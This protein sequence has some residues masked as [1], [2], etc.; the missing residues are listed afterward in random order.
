MYRMSNVFTNLS[1][2]LVGLT[3]LSPGLVHAQESGEISYKVGRKA[4]I[5]ITNMHGLITVQ[6]S[7]TNEVRVKY[8]SAS[9]SVTF[10][11]Q[12]HGKRIAL[13]A[14]SDQPGTN[15]CEYLVLVPSMALVTVFGGG[16]IRA[17]GLTGDILLE[18]PNSPLEIK[19]MND[20]HVHIKTIGGQITLTSVHN[21]H[22]YVHSINGAIDISDAADSWIEADSDAGRIAYQ[23]DPGRDGEYRLTTRSGDLEISIPASAFAEIRTQL[24]SGESGQ[25]AAA[26]STQRETTFLKHGGV[27]RSHFKLRSSTGRIRLKRP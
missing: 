4:V 17:E 25:N 3:V 19:N 26:P 24:R 5:S 22:V 27:S 14:N 9:K 8:R 21:T 23:G 2:L 12:K 10:D 18:T 7:G 11:H 16:A 1:L 15:L 6:S 20:A 13:S